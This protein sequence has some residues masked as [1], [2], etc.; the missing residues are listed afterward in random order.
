MMTVSEALANAVLNMQQRKQ[1]KSIPSQNPPSQQQ[2]SWNQ[3]QQQ[4][5]AVSKNQPSKT[6]DLKSIWE[7]LDSSSEIWAL[8]ADEE[9][10]KLTVSRYIQLYRQQNI[11]IHKPPEVYVQLIDDL[12]RG[13]S[14]FMRNNFMEVLKMVAIIEYDFDNGLDKGQMAL[15]VLGQKAYEEN[16]KRLGMN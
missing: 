2:P 16:R 4:Q 12:A 10:K 1:Q 13:N 8:I 14:E 3:R 7:E 6:V 5:Y 9:P 15:K 11:Y